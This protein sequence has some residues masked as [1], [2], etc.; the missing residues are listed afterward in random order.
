MSVHVS[1]IKRVEE[2][3]NARIVAH[4]YRFLGNEFNTFNNT[5]V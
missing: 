1:F 2:E 4:L 3:I 5:G